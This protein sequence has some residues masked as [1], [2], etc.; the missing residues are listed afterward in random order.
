MHREMPAQDPRL[1][2]NYREPTMTLTV[3]DAPFRFFA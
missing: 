2:P 1:P 3:T